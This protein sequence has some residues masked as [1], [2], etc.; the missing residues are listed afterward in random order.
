DGLLD[1]YDVRKIVL[2][3]SSDSSGAVRDFMTLGHDHYRM[4]DS[5]PIIDGYFMTST[6]G[7]A[8]VERVDVPTIAMPTTSEVVW[9]APANTY[10]REDGDAPG[11]QYRMYEVAAMTHNDSR[12]NAA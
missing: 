5:S 10:R 7:G 3:G 2:T 12:E 11:N 9:G 8:Q 6:L 1:G 4:G